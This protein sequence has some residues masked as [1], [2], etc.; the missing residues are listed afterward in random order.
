MKSD[1]FQHELAK[2][3]G[4]FGRKNDV[5]VVFQGEGA[6]TDGSTIILPTIDMNAD[7]KDEQAA[8]MRGYVDHEAGHVR[9]S[10]FGALHAFAA[11]CKA[12]GNK[13]ARALHNALEDIWL[14]RRVRDEY[15]GSERNLKAT[16]TAVN[17]Q[18]LSEVK[19]GDP[20]LADD[21]F[22]A[23]VAITWEGRK[24]YGGE[25][26]QQCIDMLPE[27]LRR[28]LPTWVKGLDACKSSGD[29]IA[30]AKTV[31]KSIRDGDYKADPDDDNVMTNPNPYGDDEDD[32]EDQGEGTGRGREADGGDGDEG[33]GSQ[34]D[35]TGDGDEGNSGS[36]GGD[37]P[38]DSG[39]ETHRGH[40][41]TD[42]NGGRGDPTA[43]KHPDEDVYDGFDLNEVVKRELADAGLSGASGRTTYAPLTTEQD[44]W[45]H[46]TFSTRRSRVLRRGVAADYDAT[47]E[48][49]RG[50]MN[51]MRRKL[52]RALVAKQQRDWDVGREFGRLD[53]RRLTSAFAGR[54]NVFKMREDRNEIDTAVMFLVDMSGSM[55][56]YEIEVAKQCVIAMVEAID[57]TGIKYE[58][59]G[60]NNQTS[61]DASRL[62]VEDHRQ[63]RDMIYGGAYARIEPLDMWIFKQF[64][65]RL[66]EAK[67]AIAQMSQCAGGNNS[68]GEAVAYA[69]ARLRKMP[70][71]RKVMMVLSDGYP[72]CQGG[73][74]RL[75]HHLRRVV[76]DMDADG[77]ECIGIGIN[78]NAVQQFYPRW[79]VVTNVSDLAGAAMDQISRVLL[80]ERFQIDNSK[81]LAS[82]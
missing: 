47:C 63:L 4:V 17:K 53:T 43:E 60:F 74:E 38:A 33:A 32:G 72:A 82:A 48:N 8:V 34:P 12:S 21:K 68:D 39:D 57:R 19:P 80:G 5:R 59:L 65:E 22:M 55:A 51:V 35:T 16:A 15:P 61:L 41:D 1:L 78:S 20:R 6:A 56:G 25:T 45:H 7:V 18:F 71:S 54:S 81:L 58:V 28:V 52:E 10:D 31:E 70:Q 73:D 27:D 79:V 46:R 44:V 11:E 64:D 40:G 2:T 66:F 50:S 24:G 13:L 9:H 3:S 37:R 29:V 23:A 69:Y 75:N 77:I 14:E 67:G 42:T 49:M 26:C 36:H 62:G 76:K 30:L